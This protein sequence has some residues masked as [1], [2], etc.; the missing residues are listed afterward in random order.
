MRIIYKKHIIF[1]FFII[2]I[3]LF[4]CS[5]E[6]VT[7]EV[8]YSDEYTQD[9][10]DHSPYQYFL[11]DT[12]T[13]VNLTYELNL[14]GDSRDVYFIFTN[15]SPSSSYEPPEFLSSYINPDSDFL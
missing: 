11:V 8:V 5:Q 6:I 13:D 15:I 10:Y 2:F 1:C 3:L 14:D 7:R 12:T 9:T 4:S